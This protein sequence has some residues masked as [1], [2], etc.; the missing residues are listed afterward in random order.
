MTADTDP[1]DPTD[2]TAGPAAVPS[3]TD[4]YPLR[5]YVRDVW[6]PHAFGSE[7]TLRWLLRHRRTNGLLA[8]GAM[9]PRSRGIPT[10]PSRVSTGTLAH[11]KG[12]R[13][14]QHTGPVQRPRR[15]GPAGRDAHDSRTATLEPERVGD[16]PPPPPAASLTRSPASPS[17][18]APSSAMRRRTCRA[19]GSSGRG[20]SSRTAWS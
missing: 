15:I 13:P 16:G 9:T 19:C 8:S 10:P 3:I 1:T 20:S 2:T 5:R 7:H 12:Q 11:G 4:L 17:W 6:E 18:R 14:R